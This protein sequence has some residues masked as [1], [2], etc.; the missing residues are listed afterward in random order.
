MEYLLFV[1][2]FAL[3]AYVLYRNFTLI[4]TYR[5]NKEYI[6]CYQA[7]LSNQENI[8]E[9][10][11][12]YIDSQKTDDFKNKGRLLKLYCELRDGLDYSKTLN[13]LDLKSVFY[14]KDKVSKA[15]VNLNSDVFIWIYLCL[16]MAR[17][18][19]KFDVLEKLNEMV[20]DLNMN[21]RLEVL[22]AN[23]LYNTLSENDTAGIDILNDLLTGNYI[24]HEY[25]KNLIGLYKRIAACTLAYSGEPIEDYYKED[26]RNF[27]STMVGQSFMKNLEIYDKYPPFIKEEKENS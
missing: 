17:K 1:L 8:Y 16:A 14:Q 13:E 4:T 12:T 24:E 25:D 15:K 26:I 6:A 11:N 3:L 10:I 7:M 27:A 20:N 22:E 18:N 2:M 19:S 9:R 5:N 21:H 23:A